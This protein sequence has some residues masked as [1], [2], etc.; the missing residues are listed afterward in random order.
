MLVA[1]KTI[2]IDAS[3]N[4][5]LKSIDLSGTLDGSFN[6]A[7]FCNYAGAIWKVLVHSII[8]IFQMLTHF[9]TQFKKIHIC[10]YHR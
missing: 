8:Y 9:I 10:E 7:C 5:A 3:Y 2:L 6:H 1:T 4:D